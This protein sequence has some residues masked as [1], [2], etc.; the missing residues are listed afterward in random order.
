MVLCKNT[1]DVGVGCDLIEQC[2]SYC[3]TRDYFFPRQVGKFFHK[4]LTSVGFHPDASSVACDGE[5]DVGARIATA[6]EKERSASSGQVGLG[7]RELTKGAQLDLIQQLTINALERMFHGTA[8]IA[9]VPHNMKLLAGRMRTDHGSV[10]LCVRIRR[11]LGSQDS[12]SIWQPSIIYTCMFICAKVR[13]Y[14]FQCIF[15]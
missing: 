11:V 5:P 15:V 7:T 4:S 6:M 9:D 1:S 12:L 14:A 10:F 2:L 8:T 3:S 13:I